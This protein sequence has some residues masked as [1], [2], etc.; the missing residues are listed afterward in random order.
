[1]KDIIDK[2]GPYR[3]YGKEFRFKY[4]PVC[5]T[6]KETNPCF[7][8]NVQKGLYTCHA[9]GKSGHIN[10]LKGYEDIDIHKLGE[11]L[12]NT[13]YPDKDLRFIYFSFERENEK[14][15]SYLRSRGISHE[16]YRQ[17]IAF[18]KLERMA[19]PISDGIDIVGIK[20]R[21]KDKKLSAEKGSKYSHLINWKAIKDREYL[22]ITEGELDLMSAIEAGF[23]NTVSMS[24]GA[25]NFRCIK[26]QKD[27][28]DQFKKIII[29]TD[30]DEPG[31][32]AKKEISK[33]FNESADKL[34]EVDLGTYKDFNEYLVKEGK[35][36]L[37][38]AI[39]K[40]KKIYEN[41]WEEFKQEENGY[42]VWGKD[43]YSRLTNFTIE[44]EK[45]SDNYLEGTTKTEQ[46]IREFKCSK[47]ELLKKQGM[48]ENL[49][50]FIG[51]DTKISKF[52]LWLEEENK[53]LYAKE[54][55][56]F[57]IINNKYYDENSE[58]V[59][60][61]KDLY[62]KNLNE[63]ENITQEEIKWLGENLV[64]IRSDYNQSLLAISWALGRY[65]NNESYPILEVCGTTS[66]G[67]SEFIENISK[68]LFGVKDNIKNFSTLTNHQIRSLA[69]CSN[70]TPFSIDEIKMTSKN[71]MEKANDLYSL[72][73]SVYDNK[74]VNQGNVTS[75][76][77]EFKLCTPLI[78]SGESELSDISIKNRMVQ[79]KLTKENKSEREIFEAFKNSDI[80]YK[81]GKRVL[82]NRLNNKIEIDLK[83][84]FSSIKDDRQRYNLKCIVQ[85]LKA[86][87]EVI[88][89]DSEV[90][91][92]FYKFLEILFSGEM[93]PEENFKQLLDL[94]VES[95]RE[96][97]S[98]YIRESNK[99]CAR[100][101]MLYEAIAESHRKT[102][103]MLE[104]LDMRALRNQLIEC[105]FI[106]ARSIST[107]F[108]IN[109]ELATSIVAKA[110]IF[111][112]VTVL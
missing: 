7:S 110:D 1:M 3:Q 83:D 74:T 85:G 14:W 44:L 68:L 13:E 41:G 100:F 89:I 43:G 45:F 31:Y 63:I 77:S 102:N 40:A 18:D 29:A 94:V 93:T 62:F 108:T 48:L 30:N 56:H 5:G 12:E 51:S 52:L 70:I 8:L 16:T 71:A 79:V 88:K 101:Q 111:K 39:K 78:V 80:L 4:C 81:L 76:L 57:G 82:E 87:E 99:H 11:S 69:S 72:I 104:L 73:R 24:G 37:K 50:Y 9:T 66:I 22:I 84:K 36:A 19:I 97:S 6:E 112:N 53:G 20:Y 46:G 107:R 106:T 92:K 58:V 28:I 21:T 98:F 49:G 61:K 95:G 47:V 75:K 32:E 59:C 105:G 33:I 91:N 109:D 17:L 23:K 64:K 34:Y 54:I 65:H 67:K 27:W 2:L 25:A 55:P 26:N 103:S 42:Y 35:E 38:K 90:K 60:G 86:L 96:Y 15:D 10:L